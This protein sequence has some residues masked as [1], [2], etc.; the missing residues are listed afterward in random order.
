MAEKGGKNPSGS[1]DTAESKTSAAV[2]AAQTNQAAFDLGF[3]STMLITHRD[4]CG[5]N[6]VYIRT[7]FD[8]FANA[9]RRI[10][11]EHLRKTLQR[12]ASLESSLPNSSAFQKLLATHEQW[13]ATNTNR[14][15][16]LR[17]QPHGREAGEWVRLSISFRQTAN[18][19]LRRR[20]CFRIWFDIGSQI[21]NC[22]NTLEREGN[23]RGSAF[24]NLQRYLRESPPRFLA[25]NDWLRHFC[26]WKLHRTRPGGEFLWPEV[27]VLKNLAKAIENAILTTPW[28]FQKI[29]ASPDLISS[30]IMVRLVPAI[31]FLDRDV[32]TDRPNSPSQELAKPEHMTATG[33][34]T[35]PAKTLETAPAVGGEAAKPPAPLTK[36]EEETPTTSIPSEY[37]T[38]PMSYKRAAQY[39][40]KGT[41]RDAAEWM[42]ERVAEGDVRCDHLTRQ[43]HVFDIRDFPANVWPKLRPTDGNTP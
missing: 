17:E 14:E 24:R 38:I 9:I 39:F 15:S 21:G 36:N 34:S 6:L 22:I 25:L 8:R 4:A 7:V 40:G 16:Y 19:S 29:G 11:A 37:R 28:Q 26:E 27:T 23:L 42:S 10:H 43:N 41:S 30:Q 12:L 13:G 35:I 2:R 18:F 32:P 31:G 3:L 33:Q 20:S 5:K 1:K